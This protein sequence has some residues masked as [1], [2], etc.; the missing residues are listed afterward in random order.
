V[1]TAKKEKKTEGIP[2]WFDC[3][4]RGFLRELR[5]SSIPAEPKM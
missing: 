3:Q 4:A 5:Y 2:F 1:E